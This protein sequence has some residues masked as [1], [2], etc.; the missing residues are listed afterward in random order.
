MWSVTCAHGAHAAFMAMYMN[1]RGGQGGAGTMPTWSNYTAAPPANAGA[2]PQPAQPAQ[3]QQQQQI[4]DDPR[5]AF[6]PLVGPNVCGY[7]APNTLLPRL[8]VPVGDIETWIKGRN[9]ATKLNLYVSLS[10]RTL[11]LVSIASAIDEKSAGEIHHPLAAPTHNMFFQCDGASPQISVNVYSHADRH[12]PDG[13]VATPP[14]VAHV[15]SG[16]LVHSQRLSRGI[17]KRVKVPLTLSGTERIDLSVVLEALDDD[18]MPLI[19]QSVLVTHVNVSDESSGW[20]VRADRQGAYIGMHVFQLRELYGFRGD[21]I[22]TAADESGQETSRDELVT[23]S[24]DGDDC[25][26]C[27]SQPPTTLILPCT[28]ALCLECAVHVRDSVEKRRM[29]E[30]QH[31]RAPR[32]QYACPICRGPIKSMLALSDPNAK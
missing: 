25:P 21:S 2:G 10:A 18:G 3:Q 31:G 22:T 15:G 27:I 4:L 12:D 17:G 29:N 11:D 32:V 1:P 24:G 30:R 5:D 19:E 16:W 20:H 13:K 26:I 23:G 8:S 28:H 6:T 7:F 9:N 14:A